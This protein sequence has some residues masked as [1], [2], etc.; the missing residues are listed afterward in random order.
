MKLSLTGFILILFLSVNLFSQ[1]YIS[2]NHPDYQQLKEQGLLPQM[3]SGIFQSSNGVITPLD[4]PPITLSNFGPD[5]NADANRSST[6]DCFQELD[7]TYQVVPFA[8]SQPPLYRND[9]ASS[10][11]IQLPFEFC[12]YGDTYNS[13]FINN[14]GNVSFNNQ[15]GTFS[16]AAFPNDF[17]MVAPFWGDVDTRSPQSGVV[18]YK[19]TEHYM[20]VI[21]D[22]VGYFSSQ[23][24]KR[25]SF[26]LI[27]S[28]GTAPIIPFGNNT[29]F[30][31]GDMQW[32]TGSASGGTNGFQGTPATV[33]ANRGNSANFVQFGRF[34]QPGGIYNG[35]FA[36]NSGIDWLDD[37]TFFFNTCTDGISTNVPPVLISSTVCETS[38]LCVGDVAEFELSFFSVEQGQTTTITTS[39]PPDSIPGLLIGN[40]SP[41]NIATIGGAFFATEENIGENQITFIATDDGDPAG[42]TELVFTINVVENNFSPLI[43]ATPDS[44]CEG[45]CTT[46]SVGE[47]DTYL[48]SNGETTPTIEVCEPGVEYT[49]QVTIGSCSG[50]SPPFAAAEAVGIPPVITGDS[51]V[52][53]GQTVQLVATPGYI[54]YNWTGNLIG[55]TV[56]VGPGTYILTATDNNNCVA[57]DTFTVTPLPGPVPTI[58]GDNI[59]CVGETSVLI[60]EDIFET[61]SWTGTPNSTNQ[62]VVG[63]G[64]YT[65]TVTDSAGCEGT[66]APFIVNLSPTPQPVIEGPSHSCFNAIVL[67]SVGGGVFD[68]LEWNTGNTNIEI[69]AAPGT[70]SV[71]AVNADGCVGTSPEFTITTSSP[72]AQI[73]D[74]IPFCRD[75][76][77]TIVGGPGYVSYTWLRNEDVISDSISV[78]TGA[79]DV[80]LIVEDEFGC[81]DTISTTLESTEPPQAAL[82]YSPFS[83]TVM[84]NTPINFTDQS[85]PTGTDTLIFWAWTF[86]PPDDSVFVQS[87]T[88]TFT[89]TGVKQITLWVV[90]EIGCVDSIQTGIYII[91][92][93]FVPNA[94]SPNGDGKNDNLKIPFLFAYPGNEVTIFNRWGKKLFQA[95]DYKNEFTGSDLPTGTY[96]Y[97]VTAPELEP[98]LKGAFMIFKD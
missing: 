59:I 14:N 26:Q 92:K 36:N 5:L 86:N 20:V 12:L 63:A 75:S 46:L 91:D 97:V 82:T 54:I 29:A 16:S 84:V 70:Y 61:Y 22:N 55:A 67:L 2:P 17:V 13:C 19:I 96:F 34:N 87:P 98:P 8:N 44:I 9:D 65:V 42:V 85:V 81:V 4:A 32:T 60:T 31:L 40:N 1:N 38:F 39:P 64:T 76:S 49:V 53:Q 7:D 25:N 18:H 89:D 77:I 45:S 30:C 71:T 66:S 73:L 83:P 72:E 50:E 52:C 93:P 78:T 62:A 15:V 10:P 57:R 69:F 58:S 41:G 56:N 11:L 90:S 51:S 80:S 23:A 35:P 47:F 48:W 28:D 79:G 21:W 43:S 27:I 88:Y 6:C 24:D 74:I 33:G 68:S 37:R 95:T 3:S 94:I